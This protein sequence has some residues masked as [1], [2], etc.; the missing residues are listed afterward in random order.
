ML[1]KTAQKIMKVLIHQDDDFITYERIAGMLE[2]SERSV[3]NYMKEAAEFCEE[4]GYQLVRR[5]GRGVCLQ[6]GLHRKELEHLFPKD[7]IPCET[8]KYRMR[9]IVR[10]LI[11]NGEPYTGSLFAEELFVS[12]STICTDIEKANK[13]LEPDRVCIRRIVGKGIIIQGRE[14]DLR[15]V[16]VCQNQKVY[17]EEAPKSATVP[18]YRIDPVT[19]AR[20]LSQYRKST[21]DKVISCIQQLER[22]I[23][24]QFNDYTFCMLAEY[25]SSQMNRLRGGHCLE[26]SMISRLTLVE[27]IADWTDILTGLLNR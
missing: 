6:A 1:S 15:K 18:D 22:Q 4:N 27:E 26:E 17:L 3:H 23:G 2:I 19:Y 9:Y 7:H 16:L 24:M 21:A 13:M 11:E 8:R 20:F 10:T 12:K 14:F 25:T 5:R